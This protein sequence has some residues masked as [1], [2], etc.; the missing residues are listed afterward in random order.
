M[1]Y[2]DRRLPAIRLAFSPA[3]TDFSDSSS[4]Q[5]TRFYY[6]SD[7]SLFLAKTPQMVSWYD[8][9]S[10]DRFRMSDGRFVYDE[11]AKLS[12]ILQNG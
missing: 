12:Y 1:S 11:R 2:L 4:H 10:V 5:G 7:I 3:R 8:I 6:G 9:R